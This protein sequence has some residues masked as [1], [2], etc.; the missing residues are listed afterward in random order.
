MGVIIKGLLVSAAMLAPVSAFA[1]QNDEE[2]SD[3]TKSYETSQGR[4]R[5]RT[6]TITFSAGVEY[7]SNVSVL[8]IDSS[9]DESDFATIFDLGAAFNVE[10]SENTEATFGYNFSQ[11]E[12]FDFSDFDTQTHRPSIG[13]DHDFGDF[14]GGLSYQY[15]Y[16]RLGGE[17]FLR[18]HRASPYIAKYL[19]DRKAYARASYVF[20]DK[21][22]IDRDDRDAQ[23]HSGGIDVF[24]FVNGLNTYVL[25]GYRYE[26]NDAS[27]AEF[28]FSSHSVKAR[29][30]QRFPFFD[31]QAK[32]RIGWQYETRDYDAVTPSIGVVRDDD[33]HR[34]RTSVEL[35][36]NDILS[37]EAELRYDDFRSNLP[38]ADFDQNVAELRLRGKL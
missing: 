17:G 24:Y 34:F 9:T 16:S 27:A 3:E 20:S 21:D 36:L 7:D 35:P 38:S 19:F 4:E 2:Y 15:I 37:V 6:F 13:V 33:R 22:F 25:G 10:L 26:V 5:E 30:V 32:W 11:D 12:Q 23:A 18:M 1:L 31:D 29:L 14:D 28:D 8:E